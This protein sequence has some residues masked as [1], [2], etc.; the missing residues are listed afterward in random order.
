MSTERVKIGELASTIMQ[1]LEEYKNLVTD[2]MK[3][4]CK[5]AGDLAKKEIKANAP[6]KT[7]KYK[8]S[9]TSKK[10]E[11]T[12]NSVQY[13]VHSPKRYQI[14]HL[15]ENGHAKRNGGR[16]KA[17]PHIKPAENKAVEQLEKDI[18][19]AIKNV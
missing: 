10:V 14:A 6:V 17:I 12:A 2:E 19:K 18:K 7:G 4:A 11:E 1:G 3:D 8:K 5:E 13:I 16:T 15:L 9:W